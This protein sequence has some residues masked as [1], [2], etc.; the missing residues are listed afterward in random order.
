MVPAVPVGR[1]WETG[2]L[3]GAREPLPDSEPVHSPLTGG[4]AT[5]GDM[6]PKEM[7]P[8]QPTTPPPAGPPTAPPAGATTKRS[9]RERSF[10][11][12]P[13]IGVGVAGLLLGALAG[14]GIGVAVAD[15]DGPQRPPAGPAQGDFRG[16][17]AGQHGHPGHPGHPGMPDAGP[18]D[19]E[20]PELPD[21]QQSQDG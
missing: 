9:W 3:P 10:G 5:I 14:A 2:W 17:G 4:L 15:D 21:E 6:E 18:D 1:L 7:N 16:P 13:V 11:L 20:L 8:Q 19:G 12:R